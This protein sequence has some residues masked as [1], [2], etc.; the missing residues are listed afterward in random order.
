MNGYVLK[1]RED[2]YYVA[3]PGQ[4]HSY[5]RALQCARIYPNREAAEAD[6]CVGNEYI[7]S[8]QDELSRGQS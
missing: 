1:R 4:K 2:G 5:T 3:P 6:Q 8:V 7:V